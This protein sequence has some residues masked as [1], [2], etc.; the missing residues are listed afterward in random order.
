MRCVLAFLFF[1]PT[2]CLADL[3]LTV[4]NLI[5]EKGKFSLDASLVY[6]NSKNN[7][8]ALG[9]YIPI[10]INDNSLINI[11][12]VVTTEKMQSDFLALFVQGK[13]GIYKDI[14]IRLAL[15]GIYNSSH[16]LNVSENRSNSNIKLNDVVIGVD[17]QLLQDAK[18]PALMLFLESPILTHNR[19]NNYFSNFTLGMTT[20]RSYDPIL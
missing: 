8:P 16:S 20:Y 6:G 14:N 18:Y 3:P 9:Q 10:K 1:T 15:N 13:Y 7:F 19:I 5:T 17:Y 12:S 2:F 4:E 11:P